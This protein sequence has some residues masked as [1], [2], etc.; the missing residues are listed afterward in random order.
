[1]AEYLREKGGSREQL[2][3]EGR[4]APTGA[5]PDL[6]AI[7]PRTVRIYLTSGDSGSRLIS[8]GGE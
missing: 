8:Y 6:Q 3:I 5:D 4:G 2:Q 7:G 1:M